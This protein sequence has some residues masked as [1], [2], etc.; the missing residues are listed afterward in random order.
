M[1]DSFGKRQ[2]RDVKAKK[3][4]AREER[5]LARNQ[6]RE[7]RAAGIIEPGSP[8]GEAHETGVD[9]LPDAAFD[10]DE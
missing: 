7:D 3:A 5:R 6:R 10:E 2:R 8:L 9:V 4:V 1:P